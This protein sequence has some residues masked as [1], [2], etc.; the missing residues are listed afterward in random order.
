MAELLNPN[1]DFTSLGQLPQV[2][3]QAQDQNTTK[4]TLAGLGQ[5]AAA[6][7]QVLM[8]SGIPSLAQLGIGM[9]NTQYQHGRDA[10][11]D[12]W[13]AQESARAQQNA[14]R[15]FGLQAAASA[16]AG[17]DKFAI[18]EVTRPDGSTGL[19]RVKTTGNEGPILGTTS[20]STPR[21]M[22]VGDIT[23][24]S[25][26]GNKFASINSFSD[27]FKPEYAGHTILGDAV[28]VAGR[29]LPEV[30]VGKSAA[31][32]A[33]WWQGY[34]RFKNVVRNELF[35]SAL[36]A[37]EKA[38]FEKAD[39]NPRMNPKQIQ[40][41][42]SIQQ[43]IA[44]KALRNKAGAMLSAGYK[45]DTVAKAYGV[46][47]RMIAGGDAQPEKT[48]GPTGPSR[49]I[50]PEAIAALKADPS[51]RAEFD[52]YYGAGTSAVVIR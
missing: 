1:V 38:A 15:S 49:Q 8:Q 24:L 5:G 20:A 18:K 11:N 3:R 41:N 45:L 39:I 13:R 25:E 29:N 22:S 36:T 28:N 12:A 10:S 44:D 9:Q 23:K 51:K 7:A 26:E 37:P 14:D 30:A 35:G 4:R 48:T 47:P 42:L 50:P 17:E 6:D 27:T 40:K 34:D 32:G 19:V 43:A 21:N 33:T 2:Y 46:D 31:D 16:R 52:A